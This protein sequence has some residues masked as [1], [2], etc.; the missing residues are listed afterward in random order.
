[1]CHTIKYVTHV[2]EHVPML[3]I[4][5]EE[6]SVSSLDFEITSVKAELMSRRAERGIE[7][8]P[9]ASETRNHSHGLID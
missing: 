2:R 4:L 1:M 8:K 9:G 5:W 6:P 3:N 7:A